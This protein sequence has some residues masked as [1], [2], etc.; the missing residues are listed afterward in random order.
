MLLV[1]KMLLPINDDNN[2]VLYYDQ[3]PSVACLDID[4][5]CMVENEA[6]VE[7]NAAIIKRPTSSAETTRNSKRPDPISLC[8]TPEAAPYKRSLIKPTDKLIKTSPLVPC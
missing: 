3:R 1:H 5:W 2:G 4:I 6:A 7:D 8:N